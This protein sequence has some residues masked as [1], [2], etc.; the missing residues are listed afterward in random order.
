MMFKEH[1]LSL[2]DS[3][4]LVLGEFASDLSETCLDVVA[5]VSLGPPS[6]GL[7]AESE[8][9]W[10]GSGDNESD[11]WN[12]VASRMLREQAMMK[13][14]LDKC[15]LEV[16]KEMQLFQ[17]EMVDCF[18]TQMELVRGVDGPFPSVDSPAATSSLESLSL[19]DA[20][21]S[22]EAWDVV[23]PRLA[24]SSRRL[25]TEIEVLHKTTNV[26]DNFV[27]AKAMGRTNFARFKSV[28]KDRKSLPVCVYMAHCV[29]HSAAR[30]FSCMVTRRVSFPCLET[31]VESML[32]RV[33]V[34][35]VIILNTI[36]IAIDG[37]YGIAYAFERYDSRA[38][39]H[40]GSRPPTWL[41]VADYCFLTIYFT[42]LFVRVVAFQGLFL[43]GPG[44]RW[45][46]F[47]LAVVLG[48]AAEVALSSVSIPSV[49]RLARILRLSRTVRTLRILRMF[50][51]VYPLQFLLLSCA[52]SLSALFWTGA[53]VLLLLFL[54]SIVLVS[55]AANYIEGVTGTSEHVE[56]L[57]DHFSS[58]PM[59]MLT[60]FLSFIGEAEFKEVI[61]VLLEVD[62]LHCLLYLFF[63]VFVTL[64][65]M[66]I[67][68]GIFI[69]EA[70]DMAS[71]DREIRQ[72]GSLQ[73]ARKNLKELLSLFYEMDE[74][75][76]G[77]LEKFDFVRQLRRPDIQSL[78]Q[79]FN[80]DILDP[81]AFFTLL[82]VNHDGLV[83]IEEFVVGCLRMHGANAIDMEIAITDTKNIVHSIDG[84]FQLLFDRLQH[85]GR[86]ITSIE[87]VLGS[88]PAPEHTRSSSGTGRRTTR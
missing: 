88:S 20:D 31:L 51:S 21:K 55:A 50:P 2:S 71:Q 33:A 34:L 30:W 54:F 35:S 87:K 79:F 47:D 52:N 67:I 23:V 59:G 86:S 68:A 82:D 49:W 83:N 76:T 5:N 3:A 44:W 58:L 17:D 40:S 56:Y 14:K 72:R 53:L 18:E 10:L 64:A 57:R 78:F 75:R 29:T 70:M 42:E 85:L 27:V 22:P 69:S 32:F 65:V 38:N 37:S 8:I 61:L 80:L 62:L 7:R 16:Q 66:N 36:C 39:V 25:S 9:T 1:E 41:Q 46:L 81:E 43:V 84:R 45:N 6:Q 63:V 60:L 73:R 28:I 24:D 15:I 4:F 13:K 77:H 12:D 74:G 48:A 26:H 19:P 11:A